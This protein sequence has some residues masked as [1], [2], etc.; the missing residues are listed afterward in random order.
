MKEKDAKIFVTSVKNASK[1]LEAYGNANLGGL[2][3]IRL[4]YKYACYSTT[5]K[6]LQ[7]IST[8]V[9]TIQLTDPLICTDTQ[10]LRSY[11]SAYGT[12][13]VVAIGGGGLLPPTLGDNSITV[14][15]TL[16]TYQFYYSTYFINYSDSQSGLVSSFIIE[17]LPA[18]G[19]LYYNGYPVSAGD[20]LT[21]IS[22]MIYTR[23]GT[24][25]YGD[26]FTFSVY[27][28]HPQ[29]PL[30]SNIATTTINVLELIVENEAPTVGDRAQY[31]ENRTTT[32]FTIEDF[33]SRPI[34]PYFD[35]E[36]NNLDAIRIDEIS[37][38]NLGTYYYFGAA[39]AVGQVITRGEIAGGAFY[40]T[41]P[42]SNS[43]STDSFN[44]SVRDTVSLIWVQ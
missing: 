41:G 15:S 35:P 32:V 11:P 22:L 20:M 23:A 6:T 21:D 19:V 4:I 1:R 37:T 13:G 27:D 44:A 29:V 7:R 17:T 2:S 25:A 26:S 3:L 34:E 28:S 14:A 24:D 16:V 43:I 31:S 18:L 8:M 5:Y 33:T 40:H 10:A 39:V 38:A 30:R 12:V 9:S 36:S 42:N